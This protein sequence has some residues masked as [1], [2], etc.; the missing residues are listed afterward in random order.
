M[1]AP[2]AKP[3]AER[4]KLI[5]ECSTKPTLLNDLGKAQ[6]NGVLRSGHDGNQTTKRRT[7]GP[8]LRAVGCRENTLAKHQ[9][10]TREP[11]STTSMSGI[12]CCSG[13]LCHRLTRNQ[14]TALPKYYA[15]PRPWQEAAGPTVT[16]VTGV[17]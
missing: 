3:T 14:V 11:S 10:A 8:I 17:S 1:N 15:T 4:S 7:M 12:R 16:N 13:E 9:R 2:T 5:S 6:P